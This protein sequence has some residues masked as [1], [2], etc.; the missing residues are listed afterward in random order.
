MIF[1]SDISEPQTFNENIVQAF[2]NMSDKLYAINPL[3]AHYL[4][5]KQYPALRAFVNEIP[6]TS[7]SV[8]FIQSALSSLSSSEIS[9]AK[10]HA[11]SIIE[12]MDE[13][14]YI[15]VG[16]K[17]SFK[18]EFFT[19]Y[20]PSAYSAIFSYLIANNLIRT[21]GPGQS[22]AILISSS[23]FFKE[24]FLP[25]ELFDD[26]SSENYLNSFNSLLS[27]YS[28]VQADNDFLKSIIEK[29]DQH[30]LELYSIIKQLEDKNY[31]TSQMTWR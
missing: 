9:L 5:T 2:E 17:L 11:T 27:N 13:Q 23:V 25:T 14:V 4:R 20:T 31:V 29:R 24:L 19:E 12:G 15:Y 28:L 30:I 26:F 21:I 8:S 18:N 10:E 22:S 1:L 7:Y 6:I 3:F 16:S